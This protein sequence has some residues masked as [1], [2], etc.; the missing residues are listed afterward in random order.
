MAWVTIT[1]LSHRQPKATEIA[2][3]SRTYRQTANQQAHSCRQDRDG[4]YRIFKVYISSTSSFKHSHNSRQGNQGY[5]FISLF[6]T[7]HELLPTGA[8][9]LWVFI[10]IERR[11]DDAMH[12]FLRNCNAD[13][14]IV[15]ASLLL[16]YACVC[17]YWQIVSNLFEIPDSWCQSTTWPSNPYIRI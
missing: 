5:A 4:C 11:P 7:L 12:I 3:P 2:T 17:V 8:L 9:V 16:L 10:F 13:Y 6:S 15:V 14:R 1:Q